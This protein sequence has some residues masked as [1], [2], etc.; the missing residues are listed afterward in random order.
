MAIAGKLMNNLGAYFEAFSNLI[1]SKQQVNG[2]V[3]IEG[4]L[5]DHIITFI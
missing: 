4:V 2:D 5:R 3:V 1:H